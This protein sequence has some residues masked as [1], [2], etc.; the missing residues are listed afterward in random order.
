MLMKKLKSSISIL[1]IT[2][3]VL[4]LSDVYNKEDVATKDDSKARGD[5]VASVINAAF[6]KYGL[7]NSQ[8][9][10][11]DSIIWIEMNEANSEQELLEYLEKIYLKQI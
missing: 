6:D 4:L 7:L 5:R 3:V 8:I 9:G 10:G 11:T 1:I 2:F